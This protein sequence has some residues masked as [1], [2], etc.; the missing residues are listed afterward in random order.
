MHHVKER[1]KLF[2]LE[3]GLIKDELADLVSLRYDKNVSTVQP[4]GFMNFPLSQMEMYSYPN[5][6]SHYEAEEK[7]IVDETD[8]KPATFRWQKK[9]SVVQNHMFDCR[10]Y[11]MSIKEIIVDMVCN[12]QKIKN[13]TWKDYCRVVKGM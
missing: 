12:E 10:V 5:Y 11:N 8:G 4:P 13:P 7:E 3:V 9:N 1:S 6:F 2:T